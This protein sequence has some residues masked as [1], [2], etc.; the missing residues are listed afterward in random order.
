MGT[1]IVAIVI[2]T[3]IYFIYP[4]FDIKVILITFIIVYIALWVYFI[5]I[6]I[7]KNKNHPYKM[8]IFILTV[9]AGWSG[10]LW[11]AALIWCYIDPKENENNG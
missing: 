6:R 1:A 8:P 11:V 4:V 10:I 2:T 7:A 3:I 5:P 9:F